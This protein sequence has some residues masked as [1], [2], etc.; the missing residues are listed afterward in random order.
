M[1][2]F[3]PPGSYLL[4]AEATGFRPTAVTDIL[5]QVSK[6]TTIDVRLEPGDRRANSR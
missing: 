6:V 2:N 1:F 5:V 4:T 3:V